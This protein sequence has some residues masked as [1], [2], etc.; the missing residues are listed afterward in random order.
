MLRMRVGA[1]LPPLT[2]SAVTGVA[3]YAHTHT[4]LNLKVCHGPRTHT[5]AKCAR[6]DVESSTIRWYRGMYIYTA[7]SR[8]R[9]ML[10]PL[11]HATLTKRTCAVYNNQCSTRANIRHTYVRT[12]VSSVASKDTLVSYV[13]YNPELHSSLNES[14]PCMHRI[15]GICSLLS[16]P[17]IT[18]SV[19]NL[20]AAC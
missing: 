8:M 6:I 16:R 10:E 5:Q 17:A 13:A 15:C 12:Y 18:R 11:C 7:A 19:A 1:A 4:G 3:T 14:C 20:A 2:K 9:C